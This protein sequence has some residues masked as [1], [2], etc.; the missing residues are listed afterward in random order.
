MSWQITDTDQIYIE[1]DN[2][3]E[4]ILVPKFRMIVGEDTEDA[5]YVYVYWCEH[6][7]GGH[8]REFHIDYNDVLF[9]YVAP[10]SASEL[11]TVLEGYIRSAFSAGGD[12]LS[13]KGDLL[14]HDGASDTVLP[15]GTDDYVLTADSTDPNGIAWKTLPAPSADTKTITYPLSNPNYAPTD[16]VTQYFGNVPLAGTPGNQQRFNTYIR[17]AGTI[18]VVEIIFSS[19]STIGSNESFSMYLRINDTTDHLIATVG[20]AVNNRVFS[21][22]AINVTVAA[23]DFF[24]I[25]CVNPAWATNPVGVY[26]SGYVLQE[27][28]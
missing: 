25:K 15:V 3:L 6:E 14:T 22:T 8:V 18:K 5:N 26:I 23:G 4:A 28:T 11:V 24:T 9:G 2:G 7:G 12:L 19:F 16:S 21:N 13:N 27:Y 17:Y 10:S 20:T 1:F